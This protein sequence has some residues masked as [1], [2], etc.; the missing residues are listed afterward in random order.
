M[1]SGPSEESYESPSSSMGTDSESP[2]PG[3]ELGPHNFYSGNIIADVKRV[4][5]ISLQQTT[6]PDTASNGGLNL[7]Q[8]A[9]QPIWTLGSQN[10][11]PQVD[12]AKRVWASRERYYQG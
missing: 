3:W 10:F 12:I 2:F 4:P 6:D 9:E 8:L 5:Q 7:D 1:K 11:Y